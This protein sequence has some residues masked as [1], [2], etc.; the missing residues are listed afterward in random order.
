MLGALSAHRASP[1]ELAELRQFL[2]EYQAEDE[3]GK[4]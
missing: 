3:K 1:R 2:A 4:P